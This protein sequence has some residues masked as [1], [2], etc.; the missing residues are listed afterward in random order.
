MWHEGDPR[1]TIQIAFRVV[2]FH[3][4]FGMNEVIYPRISF[5]IY[6]QP[7]C[8][9][10]LIQVLCMQRTGRQKGKRDNQESLHNGKK[11]SG[12]DSSSKFQECKNNGKR[13]A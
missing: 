5:T 11:L 9:C 4:K 12:K 6:I 2:K 8:I 10:L 7:V 3:L 1:F 13:G